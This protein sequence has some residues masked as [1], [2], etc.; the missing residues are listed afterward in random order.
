MEIQSVM[1]GVQPTISPRVEVDVYKI[2]SGPLHRESGFMRLPG[3]LR[4]FSMSIYSSGILSVL[5]NQ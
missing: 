1:I 2:Y 3:A 5:S 4:H